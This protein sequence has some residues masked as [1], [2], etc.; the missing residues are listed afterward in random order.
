MLKEILILAFLML[1]P[2]IELRFAIPVGLLTFSFSLPFGI[3]L[4]GFGM[5]PF[6]VFPL[7][8]LMGFILAFFVFNSLHLLDKP[9]K[10]SRFSKRYFRLLESVQKRIHPYIEKYGVLGLA[11][12]ISLPIPGSG[13]YIGSIG[14]Y[15][16]GF[17]KKKFYLAAIIGVTIASLIMTLLVSLGNYLI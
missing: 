11:I 13:V 10:K 14:G 8:I 9:L 3:S 16:L 4:T 17:E 15:V 6:L 7:A 1:I 2:F 12:Y 5:S